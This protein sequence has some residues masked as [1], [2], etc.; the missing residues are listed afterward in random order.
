MN[1]QNFEIA[2]N[3]IFSIGYSKKSVSFFNPK[4]FV[5]KI[6]DDTVEIFEW[7]NK[8]TESNEFFNRERTSLQPR[9]NLT[10]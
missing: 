3:D 5:Y 9:F 7:R 1:I 6:L 2:K 10:L 4:M 8:N